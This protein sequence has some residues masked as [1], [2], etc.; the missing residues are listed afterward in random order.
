MDPYHWMPFGNGPRNCIGMRLAL[1]EIKVAACHVLKGYRVV[2]CEKTQVRLS[3][4]LRGVGTGAVGHAPHVGGGGGRVSFVSPPPAN[5]GPMPTRLSIFY[6]MCRACCLKVLSL[7]NAPHIYIYI[8]YKFS[9]VF[10]Q[11]KTK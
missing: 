11:S 1:T 9:C 6:K 2:T 8:G 3:V 5:L 7:A 4:C 10:V